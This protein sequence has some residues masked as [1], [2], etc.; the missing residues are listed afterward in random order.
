M[1]A[2]MDAVYR[3][4]I[5]LTYLTLFV[6]VIAP[7]LLLV[8]LTLMVIDVTLQLVT[9]MEG[10]M[11]DNLFRDAW[12]AQVQNATWA[13]TGEGEFMLTIFGN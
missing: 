4:V 8:G 3:V 9:G 13:L 5:G 7:L 6:F 12:M 10:I 11:P 1:G 2:R